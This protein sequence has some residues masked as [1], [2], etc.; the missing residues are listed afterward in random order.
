QSGLVIRGIVVEQ[1]E[2][3]SI[4]DVDKINEFVKQKGGKGIGWIRFRENEIVSPLKKSLKDETVGNL[5]KSLKI[6]T[7]SLLLF[8]GGEHQW[9][10]ETLGEIRLDLCKQLKLINEKSLNFLWVVDFPL[11]EYNNEED[12]IQCVHHPFTSPRVQDLD[13]LDSE[14]L[15]AKSRAYDLVLNG[16]EIGG[17]SIRIHNR[18]LQEKIFSILGMQPDEYNDRF[19]FL[20]DALSYGAPPHG[21][22][23]FGLDRLVMILRNEDSI[24][25]TIAFPKTQKGV[26]PLSGAPGIVNAKQLRDLYI[27]VDFEPKE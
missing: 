4:K 17:G 18:L 12:R 24:R 23:A 2:N 22:L 5:I 19:G 25:E 1:G 6:K 3:V 21:G 16:T 13:I 9:V 7:G 11:F 8:L 15:K 27:R 26:C 10:C 20:L 14:P